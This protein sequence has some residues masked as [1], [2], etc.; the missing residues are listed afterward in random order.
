[1]GQIISRHK[2]FPVVGWEN[3]A[4]RDNNT[5]NEDSFHEHNATFSMTTWQKFKRSYKQ[6]GRVASPCLRR[7]NTMGAMFDTGLE[8]CRKT[9]N[10]PKLSKH[11]T[12][13]AK[14]NPDIIYFTH[15]K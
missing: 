14:K 11:Y 10:T 9:G 1:M 4:R 2:L 7:R 13:N 3:V 5:Q 8:F 12:K 15:V 6:G